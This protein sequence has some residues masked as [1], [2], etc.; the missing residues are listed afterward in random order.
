MDYA[1]GSDEWVKAVTDR[2]LAEFTAINVASIAATLKGIHDGIAPM[3]EKVGPALAM[4]G[5]G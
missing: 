4:M 5:L 3:M 2:E 1:V